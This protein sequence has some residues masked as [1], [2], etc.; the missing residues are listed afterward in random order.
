MA[1]IK[2]MTGTDEAKQLRLALGQILRYSHFLAARRPIR[3]IIACEHEPADESW[4]NLCG[5][6]EVELIW[7][8]FGLTFRQNAGH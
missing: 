3:K 2:S 4:S 8:P 1:E 7:P 6:L 5:S